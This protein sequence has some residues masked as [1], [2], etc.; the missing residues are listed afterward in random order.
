M[1]FA[2]SRSSTQTAIAAASPDRAAIAGSQ[3]QDVV[4]LCHG[5]IAPAVV[6]LS[7]AVWEYLLALEVAEYFR[8]SE[9]KAIGIISI[10]HSEVS[11]WESIA[12]KVG[13]PKSERNTMANAFKYL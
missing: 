5:Q 2:A 8:V 1:R 6:V 3:A 10:I 7:M 11:K 9:E 13:I 4:G 12:E